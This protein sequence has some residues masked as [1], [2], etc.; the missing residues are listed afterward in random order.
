MTPT[1][2]AGI[3]LAG[4]R[5]SRM[6]QPKATLEWHGSTLLR[7]TTGLLARAVDGPVVVVRAP[8]QPLPPL[9]DAVAVVD[10]PV[11]GLGPVQGIATGLAAVADRADAAFVCSTDLPFLHPAYVRRVLRLLDAGSDAVLP[12]ARGH[13]Q[14]LAA[15]YRAGLAPVLAQMAADRQLKLG[16]LFERCPTRRADDA[17]LLADAHLRALDPELESVVNVN[18]PDDYRAARARPAPEITVQRYGALA[19]RGHRGPGTVAAATLGAAAAAVEL[20][21]DRHVVAALN[22]DQITRDPETPLVAGDSVAFLSADA[23][24]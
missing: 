17:D 24:G 12:H 2:I 1:R 11:E 4:G 13:R 19:S 5:S 21:L 9:P 6:G 22:G 10:D 14:P 3:V 8:G 7:R 18:E 20:P 16:Q 23:G 15:A